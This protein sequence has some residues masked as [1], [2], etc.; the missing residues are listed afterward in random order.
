METTRLNERQSEIVAALRQHSGEWL[1]RLAL[2]RELGRKRLNQVD[3]EALAA[4]EVMG[5][6]EVDR[7]P[8]KRLVG[9]ILY[10]RAKGE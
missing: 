3:L 8:D 7:R 10:Y 2:A 4:L 5:S 9:F 6:I 1:N